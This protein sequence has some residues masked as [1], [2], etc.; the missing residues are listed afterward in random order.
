ME[1]RDIK[2][3]RSHQR[4]TNRWSKVADIGG[5]QQEERKMRAARDIRGGEKIGLKMMM[6]MRRSELASSQ[7]SAE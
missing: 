1:I 5:K 2:E 3:A 4:A 6:R 7:L